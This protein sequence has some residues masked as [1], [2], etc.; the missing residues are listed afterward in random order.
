MA[1]RR[2]PIGSRRAVALLQQPSTSDDG[3]GGQGVP[4]WTTIAEP[5]VRELPADAGSKE[6]LAAA[7]ITAVRSSFIDMRYRDGVKTTMR[8]IYRGRTLQ[9]HAVSDPDQKRRR[10][11]L[12]CTETQ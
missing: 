4:S 3:M 10:L 9:I 1:D 7:Q 6:T 8:L 11:V 5:L 2:T 12:L